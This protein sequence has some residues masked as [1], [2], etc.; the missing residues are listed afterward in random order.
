MCSL[1]GS[2]RTGL[3]TPK[4][5]NS[6]NYY[7]SLQRKASVWRLATSP[8]DSPGSYDRTLERTYLE[9]LFILRARPSFCTNSGPNLLFLNGLMLTFS[10]LRD[11]IGYRCV[12]QELK[13]QHFLLQVQYYYEK[14]QGSVVFHYFLRTKR[15]LRRID[16][17]INFEKYLLILVWCC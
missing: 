14:Y 3:V 6:P 4:G 7:N 10:M 17:L 16:L 8:A 15:V 9:T 11:F 5:Y 2:Y 12:V 1:Q 13:G